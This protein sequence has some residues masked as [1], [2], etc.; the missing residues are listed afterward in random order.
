M[1]KNFFITFVLVFFVIVNVS[2]EDKI[3]FIDLNYVYANSKIGKKIIKETQAKQKII[4]KEFKDFQKKLD[5]EKENLLAQKNVLSEEE[6]KNKLKELETNL[7]NYNQIIA[8]KN[9]NL[10]EFQKKNK[11][12]FANTLKSTL[13]TY[14]KENSISMILRKENLL[15]GKSNL[16]ITK[17]IL[18]L[19]NKS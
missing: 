17:D 14:S 12:E 10:I 11:N 1:Y 18:D 8:K 9:Q 4:S 3:A 5:K 7:Q 16:D 6:F 15:I 13:E 19:F 2:A